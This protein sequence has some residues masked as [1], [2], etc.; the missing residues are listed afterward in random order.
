MRKSNKETSKKRQKKI[1][2]N[3]ESKK[4]REKG[5]EKKETEKNK[6]ETCKQN[7]NLNNGPSHAAQK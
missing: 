5:R 6:R 4:K 3:K 1:W 7:L 2:E